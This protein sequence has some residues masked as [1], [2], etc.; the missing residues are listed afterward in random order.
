MFL[1]CYGLSKQEK[2]VAEDLVQKIRA[3]GQL[4]AIVTFDPSPSYVDKIVESLAN[5]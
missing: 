2:R 3:T 5:F 1:A 4:E